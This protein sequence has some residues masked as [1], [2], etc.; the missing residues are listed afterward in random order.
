VAFGL[1]APICLGN[2]PVISDHGWVQRTD[3]STFAW[4]WRRRIPLHA[5]A[6]RHAAARAAHSAARRDDGA[7]LGLAAGSTR[8]NL[9]AVQIRWA[10]LLMAV[11]G[12]G[13]GSAGD[14]QLGNEVLAADGFKELQGKR[15]G[16]ITNP[17]GINHRGEP[18]IEVLRKVRGVRLVALFGPEHGLDGRAAAGELIGHRVDQL[19]G[20]PVYSLYGATRKPTPAMLKGLDALVY[21]LQDTG[22]RSY[23]FISTMGLAMEACAEAGIE[24]VVLDRPNPLGGERVEGP[25]VEEPFRSFVSQ[26][27]IPYVYG[28]TCGELARMINGEGWI[29]KPCRLTVVP[30]RGWRRTMVWSDTGLPWVPPSP[31]ILHPDSPLYNA[32]TGLFGEIAG[33]SGINTGNAIRRPF[34]CVGASWLDAGRLSRY[35]NGLRL[36]GASFPVLK[37]TFG[38][39]AYEGIE[40]RFSDPARAPLVAINYY[41]FEAIRRTSGRDLVAEAVHQGRSFSLFDKANGSDSI[42]RAL[43]AQRPAAEIVNSWKSGEEGFRKRRERYLVY[44][45][46]QTQSSPRRVVAVPPPLVPTIDKPA[47][48]EAAPTP[49][50][51]QPTAPGPAGGFLVVTVSRSDTLTKI[52]RDFGVSFNA[53]VAANPGTN[54]FDLKVGQKLRIPRDE[55]SSRL[56]GGP[57]N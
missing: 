26:W 1:N 51:V 27:D 10:L 35:L 54:V 36:A 43:R 14:V 37:V 3:R 20:L 30:M 53:L 34:E 52:A 55:P 48:V 28:L 17:S 21:D 29:R 18:T 15:V 5:S 56:W 2:N 4:R 42:R 47:R 45:D 9:N 19:T 8:D 38:G 39:K 24:F 13:T 16:L 40:I 32:A 50:A 33:G 23:T 25:M 12:P 6:R 57:S 44:R 41:L 7:P 11:L 31:R 22:V 46:G 49:P